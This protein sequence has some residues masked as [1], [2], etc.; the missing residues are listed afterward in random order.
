MSIHC[1]WNKSATFHENNRGHGYKCYKQKEKLVYK[2]NSSLL[3]LLAVE[4]D[5]R[6][7]FEGMKFRRAACK[8]L[9]GKKL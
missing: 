9:L 6:V 3:L 2:G 4:T 1:I 7:H 5:V 8:S